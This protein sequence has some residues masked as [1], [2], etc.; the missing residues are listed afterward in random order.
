MSNSCATAFEQLVQE[1]MLL[2]GS[3]PEEA[4]EYRDYVLHAIK[5]AKAEVNDT[6]SEGLTPLAVA[7]QIENEKAMWALLGNGADSN[8]PTN[9][10]KTPK[11]M[12]Q[13][14]ASLEI[15]FENF[16]AHKD[17]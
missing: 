17:L 9:A 4:K 10:G 8:L 15:I 7:V 2:V 12:A 5:K 6:N 11:E 3:T 14:N 1:I 16:E 13:G